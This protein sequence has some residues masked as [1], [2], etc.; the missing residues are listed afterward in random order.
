MESR[1]GK[2]LTGLNVTGIKIDQDGNPG[3]QWDKFV[4]DW[5]NPDEIEILKLAGVGATV[6]LDNERDPNN[7]KFWNIIGAAI[8]EAG[9]GAGSVGTATSK[10]AETKPAAKTETK[11]TNIAEPANTAVMVRSNPAENIR[12]MALREA[13][14]LMN[15]MLSSDER[16]KKLIAST[17]ATAEIVMQLTLENASKFESFIKGDVKSD[18]ESDDRDLD[19][20][21]VDADEPKL[22]GDDA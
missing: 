22:P 9:E 6:R 2:I 1:N 15:S 12:A 14:N 18:V 5:K 10:P 7:P 8:M 21:G 17:K 19:N 3:D 13:I 16:F 20:D 11:A 4:M